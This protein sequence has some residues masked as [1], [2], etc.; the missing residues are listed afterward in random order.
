MKKV[1]MWR[2]WD[3]IGFLGRWFIIV[4]GGKGGDGDGDGDVVNVGL[5][6]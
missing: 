4:G 2:G 1:L 3:G 5:V 6:C